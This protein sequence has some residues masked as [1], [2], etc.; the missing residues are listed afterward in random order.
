LSGYIDLSKRRVYPKDLILCEERFARAKA[1]N[2][3]LRY[4]AEQLGYT[5]NEQLEELYDK[6]AFV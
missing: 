4:V 3:I 2:S 1:I 5:K 6:V